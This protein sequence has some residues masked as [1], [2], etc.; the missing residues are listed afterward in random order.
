[1]GDIT[2]DFSRVEFDCHCGCGANLTKPKLVMILQV[3]RDHFERPVRVISGTRCAR[4]NRKVKGARH[5]QHLLGT[6]A[7]I[8]IAG[9]APRA[10]AKFAKSLMPGYG[11]IKPYATFCH[12]DIRPNQWRG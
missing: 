5:S 10:V 1:M 12:L 8:S 11:G 7:D 6:A 4:H 2:K 3:I 9:I